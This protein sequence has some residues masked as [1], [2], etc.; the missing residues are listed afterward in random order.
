[1]QRSEREH[2]RLTLPLDDDSGDED[3]ARAYLTSLCRLTQVY[4]RRR[5]SFK[6][7][8]GG[9]AT[10]RMFIL[11]DDRPWTVF[12]RETKMQR[13]KWALETCETL[14]WTALHDASRLGD[15]DAVKK[16][17]ATREKRS[18]ASPTA[19]ISM[20]DA[21]MRDNLQ[22][23]LRRDACGRI[24]LHHAVICEQW[25]IVKWLLKRPDAPLQLRVI[26]Y[27][28][29]T[30]VHYALKKMERLTQRHP[31]RHAGASVSSVT[32][33]MRDRCPR[34][35][36]LW[37]NVD[38]ML[39]RM[40]ALGIPAS[41]QHQQ[42]AETVEELD[43][44]CRGDIWDACSAG[45]VKRLE[46]LVQVYY[47]EAA[48]A[49]RLEA[50]VVLGE[51][52]WSLLHE[53]CSR[54]HAVVAHFLLT[55]ERLRCFRDSA[56]LLLQDSSGCTAMHYAAK[57]QAL[58]VCALLVDECADL[59][60]S[61]RDD[62]VSMGDAFALSQDTR[63]RTALHWCLMAPA[64]TSTDSGVERRS[65]SVM[66]KFLAHKCPAALHVRDHDGMTPLHLAVWHGDAEL[67]HYFLDLGAD[68]DACS[69]LVPSSQR[70][71]GVAYYTKTKAP[72]A[73]CDL[74]FQQPK[75]AKPST[76]CDT[77]VNEEDQALSW[78]DA[79]RSAQLLEDRYAPPYRTQQACP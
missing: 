9:K 34:Y 10:D 79:S 24:A 75:Q 70:V 57:R 64:A 21:K 7:R 20:A 55:H 25:A 43:F 65:R 37:R 72:W 61:D 32:T 2:E 76:K 13:R 77:E 68:A 22:C 28:H 8:E 63:G 4:R 38:R 66:A 58:D 56:L 74:V 26:D 27:S 69:P 73:P 31:C 62:F 78:S 53:A 50:D 48:G 40:N 51:L 3:A 44:R 54:S 39:S 18:T 23:A 33:L 1:M 11:S 59:S 30:A 35:R 17:F 45:D 5:A 67:V 41:Q 15:L 29:R 47:N 52:R 60:E 14:Q 12:A 19:S 42:R 16:T 6:A 49:H 71:D 46:F 36:R